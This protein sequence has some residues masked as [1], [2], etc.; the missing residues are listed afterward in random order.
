M[1]AG[2]PD[3]V[4]RRRA[5][6]LRATSAHASRS[7]LCCALVCSFVVSPL[8][9]IKA[10]RQCGFG[11]GDPADEELLPPARSNEPCRSLRR[12]KRRRGITSALGMHF[13]F[14]HLFTVVPFS[15]ERVSE[16]AVGIDS[17]DGSL[18]PL[19]GACVTGPLSRIRRGRPQTTLAN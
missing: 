19:T 13:C 4:D 16:C 18:H 9:R 7:R 15:P 10:P 12:Y 14:Q 2:S 11:S 3:R 5:P 8:K 1:Q 17:V 6:S